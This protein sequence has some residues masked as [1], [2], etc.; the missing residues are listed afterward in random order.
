MDLDLGL[1]HINTNYELAGITL[2][3]SAW[4]IHVLD[5]ETAKMN[6]WDGWSWLLGHMDGAPG[7]GARIFNGVMDGR[8]CWIT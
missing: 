3:F 6:G 5:W 4:L 1:A 2:L 8:S 7:V